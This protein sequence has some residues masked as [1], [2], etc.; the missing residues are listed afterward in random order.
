[1]RILSTE[2]KGTETG[3]NPAVY[4][5]S[6]D[7]ESPYVYV[8]RVY[9]P[10]SDR[11]HFAVFHQN[12]AGG[13]PNRLGVVP[14]F[15]VPFILQVTNFGLRSGLPKGG[16]FGDEPEDCTPDVGALRHEVAQ[17]IH[18]GQWLGAYSNSNGSGMGPPTWVRFTVPQWELQEYLAVVRGRPTQLSSEEVGF[19]LTQGARFTQEEITHAIVAVIDE[20][21]RS[22]LDT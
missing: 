20:I 10:G 13:P 3:F 9:N 18:Q 21:L 6:E 19:R 14:S 22:F 8:I 4:K 16:A 1:V 11:E 2:R 5:V 12:G 15:L 17:V 7:E